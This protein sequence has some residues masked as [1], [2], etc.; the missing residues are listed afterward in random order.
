MHRLHGSYNSR[1]FVVRARGEVRLHRGPPVIWSAPIDDAVAGNLLRIGNNGELFFRGPEGVYRLRKERGHLEPIEPL[2]TLARGEEGAYLGAVQVSV[3][4]RDFCYERIAPESRLSDKLFRLLRSG[5]GDAKALG[6]QLYLYTL[7]GEKALNFYSALVDPA[8]S[9]RFLWAISP[10]FKYLLVSQPDRK[11]HLLFQVID[12]LD[13]AVMAEFEM[14][15]RDITA[16]M[17]NDLGTA[18]LEVR[19]PGD[20]KLVV[21][22]LNGARHLVGLPPGSHV[23]HLGDDWVAVETR[24]TP[25]M[26]IKGFD[27]S[28]RVNADL[29]PLHELGVDFRICF[30]ERN[31]IDILSYRDRVLNVQHTDLQSLPTDAKRWQLMARQKQFDDEERVHREASSVQEEQKKRLDTLEKSRLLA[32]TMRTESESMD[33]APEP[34]YIDAPSLSVIPAPVAAE[35]A[36]RFI[37]PPVAEHP[38]IP[39]PAHEMFPEPAQE[40]FAEPQPPMEQFAEPQP[41]V[42]PSAERQLPIGQ[43][44]EPQPPAGPIPVPMTEFP[45]EEGLELPEPEPP[46]PNPPP[47]TQLEL[48]TIRKGGAPAEIPL[49]ERSL[50]DELFRASRVPPPP[51]T[52]EPEG[53]ELIVPAREPV[54]VEDQFSGDIDEE[55]ERLR[56]HYI[57]GEIGRDEYYSKR[58]E[59]ERARKEGRKPVA[60]PAASPP[61]RALELEVESKEPEKDKRPPPSTLPLIRGRRIDLGRMFDPGEGGTP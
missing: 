57:A 15:V 51:P 36:R 50:D 21:S 4:G 39:E 35:S 44:A 29:R 32:A 26:I 3:E 30:N 38:V 48:P 45:Q 1:F 2:S 23:I 52:T 6:H 7:G 42:G 28:V 24:P 43:F 20:E 16:V 49:P 34:I 12:I 18:L 8:R 59:L 25:F 61:P 55:L 9:D 60:P 19:R 22:M 40:V 17:V 33:I 56:M 13:E 41:P 14:R 47:P 53:L 37:E 5:T 11:G 10:T 27:D 54:P 31:D 58:A 46:L